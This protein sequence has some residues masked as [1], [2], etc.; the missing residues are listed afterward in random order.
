MRRTLSGLAKAVKDSA[1][2]AENFKELKML[3]QNRHVGNKK[4]IT[5]CASIPGRA[6]PE[7]VG[8][9]LKKS[10]SGDNEYVHS[11]RYRNMEGY[12][13]L[14]N[15]VKNH[16][17]EDGFDIDGCKP[18]FTQSIHQVLHLILDRVLNS[19]SGGKKG[20]KVLMTVPCFG[21]FFDSIYRRGFNIDLTGLDKSTDFKVTPKILEEMLKKNPDAKL[22]IFVNPDNP[23]GATYT[24]KE[25]E[26]LAKVVI[27]HNTTP[28]LAGYPE[29]IVFSDEA[30]NSIGPI[31]FENGFSPHASF[32]ACSKV[33]GF[34][35]TARSLSKTLA[36]SLGMCLALGGENLVNQ[37]L[38]DK[39]DF[40]AKDFGPSFPTQHLAAELLTSHSSYFKKFIAESN[41]LYS[42]NLLQVN[43]CID[44]LNSELGDGFCELLAV[45]KG[46]LQCVIKIPGL[47]G[48]NAPG[49]FNSLRRDIDF[50]ELLIKNKEVAILP[51]SSCGFDPRSMAFRVTIS[52]NPPER[53]IEGLSR[54]ED[55]CL[56]LGRKK[57]SF[58]TPK[59]ASQLSLSRFGDTPYLP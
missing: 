29:M 38:D 13:H 46:G 49:D 24:K 42:K 4:F 36:P 41:E 52:K 17:A 22:W 57:N 31:S 2:F 47:I 26:S 28:R 59:S 44:R 50:S 11:Y 9:I 35:I 34:T 56:E 6:V 40:L 16:Y 14:Q 25:L 54:I 43:E 30:S 55:L 18:L 3:P 7:M 21:L 23:T 5:L 8:D 32:G 48:L 53:L 1:D 12:E 19:G 10:Y 51:G 33:S 58:I 37:I 15:A 45:P 39:E 27:L 20:D